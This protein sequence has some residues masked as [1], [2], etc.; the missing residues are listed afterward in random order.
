MSETQK[1]VNAEELYRLAYEYGYTHCDHAYYN[2]REKLANSD[3][4]AELWQNGSREEYPLSDIVREGRATYSYN[5]MIDTVENKLGIGP[6]DDWDA[7]GVYGIIEDCAMA[8]EA[9]AYH[10]LNDRPYDPESVPFIGE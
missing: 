5:R 6:K 4:P 3:M 2:I 10:S 9:A 1:E 8:W 7:A